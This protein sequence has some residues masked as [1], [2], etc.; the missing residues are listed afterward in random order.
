MRPHLEFLDYRLQ[1]NK[2]KERFIFFI[3]MQAQENPALG[4]YKLQK[5][6]SF[7]S[8]YV[9]YLSAVVHEILIFR[10]TTFS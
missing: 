8:K 9:P 10:S 7:P 4:S 3:C 5:K 6:A 2:K 1:S